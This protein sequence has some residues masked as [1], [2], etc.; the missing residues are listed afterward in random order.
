VDPLP[1]WSVQ[2]K[3]KL[4]KFFK[5]VHILEY[6]NVGVYKSITNQI[7]I[8]CDNRNT[9]QARHE[10]IR[11]HAG[12]YKSNS[13]QKFKVQQKTLSVQTVQRGNRTGLLFNGPVGTITKLP[14]LVGTSTK[15]LHFHSQSSPSTN[16]LAWYPSLF[17]CPSDACLTQKQNQLN[18]SCSCSCKL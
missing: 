11:F 12:V 9:H 13:N 15:V 7:Q 2:I 4:H 1:C 6:T 14:A 8:K 16:H 10:W 5:R 18:C 3:Y 17:H